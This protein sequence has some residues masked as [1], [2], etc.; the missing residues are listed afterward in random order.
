METLKSNLVYTEL[1]NVELKE[2]DPDEK[3]SNKKPLPEDN[4]KRYM[5]EDDTLTVQSTDVSMGTV[6]AYPEG[7]NFYHSELV[8]YRVSL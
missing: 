2:K 8:D 3:R 7:I 6:T 5:L 1:Y 4:D